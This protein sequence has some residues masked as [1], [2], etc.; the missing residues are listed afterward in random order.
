L[1]NGYSKARQVF[2]IIREML[3][4]AAFI[5]S[6]GIPSADVGNVSGRRKKDRK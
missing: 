2:Q 4:Q 5:D 1:K 6:V 3:M